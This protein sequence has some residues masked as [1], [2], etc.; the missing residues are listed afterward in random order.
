MTATLEEVREALAADITSITGLRCSPYLMD[1][2]NPP[3]GMLDIEGPEQVTFSTAGA[4]RYT[5]T[6]LVFDQRASEKAAQQR[7]DELRDPFHERSL[8]RAIDDGSSLNA[9]SG[10]DYPNVGAP[11]ALTPVQVGTVQYLA[12]EFPIEI[13]IHQEDA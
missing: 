12:C 13:V 7:V 11:T 10:L 2:A 4:Q 9:L 5:F 3:M 6:L 1:Q 8:K